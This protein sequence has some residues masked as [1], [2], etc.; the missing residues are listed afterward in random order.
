[1]TPRRDLF[2]IFAILGACGAVWLLQTAETILAPMVLAFG[3]GVVMAPVTDRIDRFGLPRSASAL[4]AL[5]TTLAAVLTGVL[6]L[7]PIVSDAIRMAPRI[8]W[9]LREFVLSLKPALDSVTEVQDAISETLNDG[10]PPVPDGEGKIEVPQLTD[11][12]WLAPGIAAQAMIFV[13]TLYFFLLSRSDI[14]RYINRDKGPLDTAALRNAELQVSRYFM[15]ITTINAGFGAAFG[16]AMTVLGMPGPIVWGLA[17]ALLNYVPY[18]GPA[19]FSAALLVAGML[20]FDGIA[21]LAPLL[22]FLTM[23]VV[24]SQFVTPAAIGRH[25]SVNPLLVFVSL[26]F[27]L[28]LW[29]PVGGIV[30][31]PV[32]VWGLHIRAA[33]KRG[34]GPAEAPKSPASLAGSP[35]R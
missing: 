2:P 15:T 10:R 26:T 9:E 17:A 12:I 27:W 8:R 7:E 3:M 23:N 21:S 14:Y 32:L 5:L 29:G 25:M 31:I 35:A 19:A 13:G 18:V 34:A 1:M 20:N 28:W 4:L 33:L 16:I 22:V 24:E 11:A 30:A 6:L